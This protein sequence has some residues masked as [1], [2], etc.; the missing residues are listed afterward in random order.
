MSVGQRSFTSLCLD[1]P[2]P[3]FLTATD[4]FGNCPQNN[5]HLS[6]FGGDT[7]TRVRMKRENTAGNDPL[8]LWGTV[9]SRT[10]LLNLSYAHSSPED[11]V[12]MKIPIQ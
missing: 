10:G 2:S 9:Q 4:F 11:L 12:K 5:H 1:L 3:Q 7:G 8:I 6:I